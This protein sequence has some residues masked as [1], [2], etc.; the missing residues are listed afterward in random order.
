MAKRLI[1]LELDA[2]T[3]E[4]LNQLRIKAGIQTDAEVLGMAVWLLNW[5]LNSKRDGKKIISI[6]R[7]SE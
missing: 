2:K 1:T 6:Y 4:I 7:Q 3:D 5:A